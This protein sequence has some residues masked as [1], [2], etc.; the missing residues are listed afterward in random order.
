M[1]SIFFVI[2]WLV[3]ESNIAEVVGDDEQSGA[4]NV[5]MPASCVLTLMLISVS[6]M[7]ASRK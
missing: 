6:V 1:H 4:G 7:A 5:G 2:F 3:F